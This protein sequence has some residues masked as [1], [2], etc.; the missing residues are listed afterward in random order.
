MSQN[1]SD[2][3]ISSLFKNSNKINGTLKFYGL[4]LQNNF[5]KV[6]SKKRGN[7]G[8][9]MLA[10]VTLII[11]IYMMLSVISYKKNKKIFYVPPFLKNDESE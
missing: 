4:S 6:T 7:F 9:I 10:I 8:F 3:N 5:T 11:I 2:N 1:K